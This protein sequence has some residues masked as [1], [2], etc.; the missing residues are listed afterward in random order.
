M[1]SGELSIAPVQGAN[2]ESTWRSP[3]LVF[4][5][6]LFF[7][8]IGIESSVGNWAAPYALRMQHTDDGIGTWAA[9]CFWSALLTGRVVCAIVLKRAAERLV[10]HGSLAM[11]LVGVALLLAS[12]SSIQVLVAASITGLGL[13]PVF[14]L[15]LSFASGS[16]LSSRN[17][18]WVFSFAALGGVAL[19]WL[20][21]WV[22]TRSNSLRE[23]L[24]V[25]AFATILI[26][27][28]TLAARRR[29][30]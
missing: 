11:A 22:S 19:P 1:S 26:A 3:S 21:G 7:M 6:A 25:P 18:G 30:T 23:G 16:L 24:V 13:A 5:A 8:Y 27:V 2:S 28:L 9:G 14:P 20:T 17:S 15:L 12:H 4:Y 10:Y 29:R